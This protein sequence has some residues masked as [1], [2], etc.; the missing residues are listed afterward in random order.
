MK[1]L[2]TTGLTKLIELS[3][4]TFVDKTDT[5]D[6]S[7]VLAD[8]ATTGSYNDLSDKPTIG[9]ATLTIQKNGTAVDTF[10]ANATTNKTINI[11]VPTT[12]ADVSAVAANTAI[13]GATKCKITYDSKGL[14]TAGAD[15]AESDIPS[16]HLS[17]IS[18]VTATATEV[19][20][21][22]GVTSNVQTQLNTITGKIPS[23][24]T[25][26]N[27]LADKAFVNSSIN[28]VAA[29]YITSDAQGDAFATHAALIAGPYYY[30]GAARTVTKN[31][32]AIVL[33]DEDHSNA[34]TR[35]TY[36]GSQWAFQYI[37]N[38]SAMTQAQINALNSG[39]T[40]TKVSN[41]D[42]HIADTTIHVTSSDKTN[43]NNKVDKTST[44]SKLYATDSNGSQTTLT[45]SQVD[46][47]SSATANA[48]VQRD[49][50]S[51]INVP[52]T[53][54]ANTHAASKKYVDDGLST[55][56]PVITGGATTIVS[57][58]LTANKALI[59][60]ASGKVAVS[61]VTNTELGYVSGVTS[62]IQT[63]LNSKQASITGAASSITSS[64]LTTSRALI[65][66]T[67][68]KVAASTT[69]STELGYVHGVTSAIQTQLDNK[70]ATLVSGT[71]IKTVNNN[72]L[73]GSGNITIDSLPSQSGQSGKYLTT[74]GTTASW[75]NISQTLS[76]LTDTNISNATN[77]QVLTYNSSTS[78]WENQTKYAMVIT[79]YTA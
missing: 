68:G 23:A 16:L 51:Q 7:S 30:D 9:N 74:D 66:N 57:N 53:P 38:D 2:T 28:A 4:D 49:A 65:S 60:N 37:V 42:T 8:V 63:Q 52:Q 79:D 15:L 32:Y 59:S 29:Y 19:N 67:S 58:D 71:N 26:S 14:V 45:Y 75:G 39:I 21:M 61:S 36:T 25:T 69:T 41:Y 73:L 70:Q 13:T 77:G 78:K 64:N 31:D 56:Q 22:G 34:C 40:S 55:K 1:V 44:A 27:Q 10:T 24:A 47:T 43:W 72:S 50:N 33:I 11:T 62:A 35:Y 48:I 18:D 5:I 46:V 12:A 76:G 6:M 17:K 54:T 3:K 20:Y